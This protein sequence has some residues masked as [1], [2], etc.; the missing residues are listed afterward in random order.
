MGV[1]VD[2]RG[3]LYVADAQHNAVSVLTPS[4]QLAARWTGSLQSPT[5]ITV[6]HTGNVYVGDSAR[7]TEFSPSGQVRQRI[8]AHVTGLATGNRGALFLAAG[9]PSITELNWN[10]KTEA[11]YSINAGVADAIAIGARGTKYVLDSSAGRLSVLDSSG[12]VVQVLGRRGKRRGLFSSPL[13]LAIG[14]GGRL[15]VADTGNNRI[16]V[17]AP[18]A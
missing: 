3:R 7:V 11:V 13:A 9:L 14:P 15:F 8:T 6:D 10:G 2:G 16:D 4:G 12:T 17:F 5:E 1:A 18:S